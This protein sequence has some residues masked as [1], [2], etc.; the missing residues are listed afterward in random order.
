M[1]A[2]VKICGQDIP[3]GELVPLHKRN[4]KLT[5]RGGYRKIVASIGAIGLIEPLAVFRE[6]GHYV[7]LDGYLRYKACEELGITTI[8]C[9]IYSDKEAYTFNRMVNH[10]SGFQEMKMLRKSLETLD[11]QTVANAFGLKSIRHRLAPTLLKQ[12][13]PQVSKAFQDD[14]LS[15]TCVTEF[16]Y[17]QPERQLEILK[18]MKS[19]TNY[20][21]TFL[22]ALILGTPDQKRNQDKPRIKPWSKD[23]S[24][25]RQ[26][27]ERLDEATRQHDFYSSLYR[28][29]STD[30]LKMCFYVRQIITKPRLSA[31]L[32]GKR[33]ELLLQLKQ[34]VSETQG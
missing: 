4:I 24:K 3:I 12:L 7:I 15:K 2:D 31:Y 14:V 9:M 20:T 11:E 29:Y 27:A 10:L 30:L 18:E 1:N 16:T 34:I 17:V 21:L 23:P 32:E 22:R 25:R 19:K 26:L 28:R 33:P 5:G 6:N 8:P 13:H